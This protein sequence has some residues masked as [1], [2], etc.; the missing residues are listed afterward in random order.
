MLVKY[1]CARPRPL[2]MLRAVEA[3]NL[4]P[5]IDRSFALDQL[6]DAFRLQLAGGHFGKIGINY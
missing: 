6:A 3:T 2:P 1:A 5:V 4:R